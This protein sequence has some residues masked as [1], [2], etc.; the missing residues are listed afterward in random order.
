MF[1]SR[2]LVGPKMHHKLRASKGEQV[3]IPVPVVKEPDALCYT[4]RNRRSV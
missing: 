4:L 2:G 3:N 1:V